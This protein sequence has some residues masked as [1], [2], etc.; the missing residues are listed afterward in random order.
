[1]LRLAIPFLIAL[2]LGGSAAA[3]PSLRPGQ[4]GGGDGTGVP[5]TDDADCNMGPSVNQTFGGTI[6]RMSKD[7]SADGG[8]DGRTLDCTARAFQLQDI[9]LQAYGGGFFEV[10]DFYNNT[11]TIDFGPS[12][13]SRT[14]LVLDAVHTLTGIHPVTGA[15]LYAASA[16]P[17]AGDCAGTVYFDLDTDPDENTRIIFPVDG[18]AEDSIGEGVT[19]RAV[20]ADHTGSTTLYGSSSSEVFI[21]SDT[22]DGEVSTS[23]NKDCTNDTSTA[24]DCDWAV[25]VKTNGVLTSMITVDGDSSGTPLIQMGALL[26]ATGGLITASGNAPTANVEGRVAIDNTADQLVYGD[27]EADVNVLDPVR[28]YC[29]TVDIAVDGSTDNYPLFITDRA[30]TITATNAYCT[31]TCTATTATFLLEDQAGNAVTGTTT[32][33]T[34]STTQSWVAVTAGG[35]FAANEVIRFDTTNDPA[36][37]AVDPYTIC[38]TYTVTRQ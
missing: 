29:S 26:R 37:A 21:D 31:G 27:N 36:S 16:C 3:L 22:E 18:Y 23:V 5:D 11:N 30:I 33:T 34:G 17:T 20:L 19:L 9:R 2:L 8:T 6:I 38:F 4:G 28:M 1:V 35:S 10:R 24:E 32:S 7:A 14:F 12:G 13:V 15:A 25:Q